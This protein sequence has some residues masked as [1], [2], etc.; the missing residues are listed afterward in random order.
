LYYFHARWYDPETGR[1]ISRDPD[2]PHI[3]FSFCGQN[4][5]NN[6]DPTGRWHEGV[7]QYVTGSLC[8]QAM[9]KSEMARQYCTGNQP[10]DICTIIA[11]CD[12]AWDEC[13]GTEPLRHPQ[14]HIPSFLDFWTMFDAMKKKAYEKC[15]PCA[16]GGYLHMLQDFY[17]HQ[18]LPPGRVKTGICHEREGRDKISTW[19]WA[20]QQTRRVTQRALKEWLDKCACTLCGC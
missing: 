6:V 10:L 16:M 19:P 8:L 18:G 13:P 15:D 4:P 1:F 11:G 12:Q 5:A 14:Y 17:A 9:A 3:R 20:Y 7:H 2:V